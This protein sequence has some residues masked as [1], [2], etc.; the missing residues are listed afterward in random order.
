MVSSVDLPDPLGPITATIVPGGDFEAEFA[1]RV[2]LGGALAVHLRHLAQVQHAH[3]VTPVLLLSLGRPSRDRGR[4][5]DRGSLDPA[6]GGVQPADHRVQPEQ[7]RVYRQPQRE[8]TAGIGF[9]DPGPLL[10]ELHQVPAVRLDHLAH[11]GARHAQ[12]Q[13]HLDHQLVAR[14][15][16][17]VRRGP[18]PGS[19]FTI[20]FGGDLEPLLRAVPLIIVVGL[21][22]PVT[23]QPL[24]R[25][26]HLPDVQR[27]DLAS[28]RLELLAQPQPVLRSLAEQRQQ[29]VPDAHGRCIVD[30]ILSMLLNGGGLGKRVLRDDRRVGCA[31]TPKKFS[32]MS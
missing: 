18:Q 28:A 10:H 31:L 17:H 20:A 16:R 19:Q 21:D 24:Q 5:L 2:Y 12:R 14:R 15:R 26:V 8:V 13:Q 25:R 6:I 22:Q 4:R 3:R 32:A 27:P 9:L 30:I 23:L 29:R 11:V 1:Q 7:L